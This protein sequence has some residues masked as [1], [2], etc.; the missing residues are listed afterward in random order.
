MGPR[1]TRFYF[2]RLSNFISC[3]LGIKRWPLITSPD[4]HKRKS[5]QMARGKDR[6]GFFLFFLSA[7][8]L[9]RCRVSLSMRDIFALETDLRP[10]RSLSAVFR[11]TVQCRFATPRQSARNHIE[12]RTLSAFGRYSI[13]QNNRYCEL[14]ESK[15]PDRV[16]VNR[17]KLNRDK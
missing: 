12:Q 4:E 14:A 8:A 1:D 17:I 10:L 11:R 13:E 16:K 9:S 15:R 3:L 6:R 5:I 7:E 2:G